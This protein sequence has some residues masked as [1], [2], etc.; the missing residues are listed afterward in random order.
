MLLCVYSER[1]PR[2]TAIWDISEDIMYEEGRPEFS[3]I[4]RNNRLFKK[5]IV[6]D[7]MINL[8]E[9]G[10]RIAVVKATDADTNNTFGRI[11]ARKVDDVRKKFRCFKFNIT[12]II[13]CL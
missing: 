11:Q 6:L 8:T 1:Q 9:Q 5:S 7:G 12:R 13:L 4:P 10:D 2:M 3:R